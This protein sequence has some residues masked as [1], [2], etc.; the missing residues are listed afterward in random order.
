MIIEGPFNIGI[1]DN[2]DGSRELHFDF[3]KEFQSMKLAQQAEEFHEFILYLKSEI[4]VLEES[5]PNHQ[6]MVTILQVSEQLLPH[7]EANEIPLDETIVVSLEVNN[8]F[9]KITLL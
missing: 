7:I 9:G 4:G 6:G 8:P 1:I 5:D 3:T 2:D